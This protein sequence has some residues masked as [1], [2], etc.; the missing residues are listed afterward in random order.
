[1]IVPIVIMGPW[2]CDFARQ[3][4]W[5]LNH[6]LT[7]LFTYK[8]LMTIMIIPNY[9]LLS[10]FPLNFSSKN[11]FPIVRTSFCTSG[12]CHSCII[13]HINERKNVIVRKNSIVIQLSHCRLYL[14]YGS[15]VDQLCRFYLDFKELG[16]I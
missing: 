7:P 11:N 1:M 4:L 9:F 13:Y 2:F 14:W 8:L 16:H 6:I 5:F 15:A 12:I 3:I 10:A